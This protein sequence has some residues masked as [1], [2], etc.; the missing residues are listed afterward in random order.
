M[1]FEPEPIDSG[2]DD[3]A[4]EFLH[5]EAPEVIDEAEIP[6]AETV[7][8][9]TSFLH[10]SSLVFTVISQLRQNLI[11]AIIALFGA[12]KGNYVFIGI[13]AVIFVL[14]IVAATVRY[15]TLRYSIQ[16]GELAVQSGLL[17]RRLRKIPTSRIQNIDLVQN[18]LH[19]MFGVAEVRVE[20]ASGTEPEAT[21]RV[22]SLKQVEQLRAKVKS[23]AKSDAN[24]PAIPGIADSEGESTTESTATELLRI[25][26]SWLV[27]AGLSSNRGMVLVGFMFGIYYQNLPDDDRDFRNVRDRIE[28]MSNII[29]DLGDGLQFWAVW[30]VATLALLLLIRILGVGWFILRFFGYQLTQQGDDFKISCGL[31]TKVSATVPVK[32]IQFISIH[33][34]MIMRWLGLASIRIE[35]AGGAGKNSEDATTTVSKRWFVPVVP[36]SKLTELMNVIRPQLDWQ[37]QSF[38]WQPLAIRASSR[39]VRGSIIMTFVLMLVGLGVSRPWG[40]VPGLVLCPLLIWYA[41]KRS[42]STK[43]AR[44]D[45]GVVFR[46]GVFTKKTSI[47]FFEKIQG[48]SLSQTPFDRRWG[49]RTL[50][51][52]TAAAGPASHTIA[53]R[54][55]D[56]GF[57]AKEYQEI[58]RLASVRN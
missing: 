42:R 29:P 30:T 24:V 38:D 39:F 43:Y 18:V 19:R 41:V 25:P 35:T 23:A 13:A 45:K 20:T 2:D 22:L 53:V 9:E 7:E 48:A 5:V 47:T 44:I 26:I 31:F 52:D 51:V 12:A 56:A 14:S 15:L 37:E 40:W 8:L 10:P 28:G 11:P 33:R 34:S 6:V 55:L 3:E 16:N 58:V 27:K 32:R 17:F 49:M 57:A 36:E 21:L 50:S 46:S 1:S 54:F 4:N